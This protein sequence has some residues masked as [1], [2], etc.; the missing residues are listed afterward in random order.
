MDDEE[1]EDLPRRSVI[2][3]INSFREDSLP[4]M[5]PYQKETEEKSPAVATVWMRVKLLAIFSTCGFCNA[6]KNTFSGPSL[7]ILELRV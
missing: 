5:N 7:Q 2:R 3:S 4:N 1:S 6:I